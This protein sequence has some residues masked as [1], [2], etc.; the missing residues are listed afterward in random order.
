MKHL[1]HIFQ[2]DATYEAFGNRRDAAPAA[3]FV[4]VRADAGPSRCSQAYKPIEGVYLSNRSLMLPQVPFG[5]GSSGRW[6][7]QPLILGR[8]SAA[9][10][11]AAVTL[12]DLNSS[13]PD[14][15]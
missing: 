6:S 9:D 13:K 7:E 3:A 12:Q 8:G 2:Y 15:A 4:L 1:L 14:A 10:P 11:P 5:A